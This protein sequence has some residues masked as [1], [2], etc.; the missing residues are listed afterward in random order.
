MKQSYK[1]IVEFVNDILNSNKKHI[2]ICSWAFNGSAGDCRVM[3]QQARDLKEAGYEVTIF[4]LEATLEPPQGVN[5]DISGC[6]TNWYLSKIY[7]LIFPL[8]IPEVVKYLRKLKK[9]DLVISHRY[10]MNFLAYLNKIF[11]GTKYV[12][13]HHHVPNKEFPGGAIQRLY[14]KLL[15]YLEQKSLI[16][17]KADYICSVSKASKKML[18]DTS[19]LDSITV[20]NKVSI[21]RF[22]NL[23][24]K[25]DYIEEKYGISRK[26]PIIL[27]VGRV[28]PTKN[29]KEL[30]EVFKDI[31]D[32]IPDSKL[33]IVGEHTVKDYSEKLKKL[34]D[35]D[36]IFT[37]YIEDDELVSFYSIC[38]VYATCSMSEGFNLPLKE[39]ESFNK[40]VVAF[41]IPA[42]REIVDNDNLVELE[43]YEKFKSK[44][45]QILKSEVLA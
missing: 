23:D 1:S 26:D 40:P 24:K 16:V 33:V 9:F 13:W 12:F 8:N 21:D 7:R 4:A 6:P 17:R 34:A 32:H 39:V 31:K 3:E 22:R 2:A 41:D 36:V 14:M 25:I 19:G 28:S 18:K 35:N 20:P 11:F 37:G 43:N 5:I 44:L 45:L 27:Y 15:G 30:I 42:H 29:V 38:D 10:P